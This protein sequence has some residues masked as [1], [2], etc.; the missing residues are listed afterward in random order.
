MRITYDK[1]VRDNVPSAIE[2]DGHSCC[3]EVLAAN[4]YISALKRKLVEEAR[5][6]LESSTQDELLL[7]LADLSEVILSLSS[8]SGIAPEAV[9]A[10]RRRR[11]EDRG[12]FGRRLLL[13]YVDLV[14]P[15]ASP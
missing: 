5:E 7:E 10:T 9:E 6:A 12:G 3:V 4:D 2:A 1:L 8:A 15:R 14:G 11:R 13:R